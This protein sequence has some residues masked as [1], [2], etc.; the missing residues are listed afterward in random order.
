MQVRERYN[1][2]WVIPDL[3][4]DAQPLAPTIIADAIDHNG[5]R[6]ASVL[7]DIL[8]PALSANTNESKARA[9][10]RRGAF[11][12][13]WERSQLNLHL[14]RAY[15]HLF[16]YATTALE[17]VP[18]FDHECMKL[19][20]RDPLHAFPEP[21]AS[22][23]LTPPSDCAYIYGKSAQWILARYP[24]AANSAGVTDRTA[25]LGRDGDLWD[26][27]EWV[28]EHD[29]VLGVLGPRMESNR[30][31]AWNAPS[32]PFELKRWANRAGRCTSIV[33]HRVTLD[34]VSSA[35]AN[36]TGI[37]DFQA[38]LMHLHMVALEKS[39]VPDTYITG[40]SSSPPKVVGGWKDGRLGEVNELLDVTNIGQLR[41]EPSQTALLMIDRLER[42]ARTNTGTPAPFQGESF[43]GARTG[44]GLDALL[45]TAVDPRIQEAQEIM[46]AALTDANHVVAAGY[47]GYWGS[48]SYKVF[49]G[50]NNSTELT[51][52][53][54]SRDFGETK[55]NK[56]FYAMPGTDIVGFN[57]VLGQLVGIE[58]MSLQT[59]RQQH[60]FIKDADGEERRVLLQKLHQAQEMQLLARAQDPNGG[61]TPVDLAA[62]IRY[63][64]AGDELADAVDKAQKDAQE[65]QAALAPPPAEGMGVSP[66]AMAGLAN[67]GEGAESLPGPVPDAP[68]GLQAL[69]GL[70]GALASPV[71]PR[72]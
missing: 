62:I 17:V 47:E 65:R 13:T 8:V 4:T 38:R 71:G 3:G 32:R 2:D 51:E 50:W 25:S 9:A 1:G 18:D 49:A 64:G 43:G 48:K 19:L 46:S 10:R 35:V 24:E 27:V 39:I 70:L 16:G 52:F 12:Y 34:R 66:E 6:A 72:V 68:Q 56:V 61:L 14:R 7:P 33:P 67:P 41:Q 28:D 30:G 21:K 23:D 44:R 63:V 40:S 15:R 45:A 20:V 59:M 11:L 57:V 31:V 36:A 60:P 53:K 37:A 29:I 69:D 55:D 5:L 54:P 58:A 22:E 42:N 26:I